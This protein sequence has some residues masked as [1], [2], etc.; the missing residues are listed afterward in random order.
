MR[1]VKE[2]MREKETEKRRKTGGKLCSLHRTKNLF[3]ISIQHL[4]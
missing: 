4:N 2:T 3:S 1:R